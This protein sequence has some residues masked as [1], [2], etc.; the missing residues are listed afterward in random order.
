MEC[1]TEVRWQERVIAELYLSKVFEYELLRIK[2]NEPYF[3]FK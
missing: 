2:I 1:Y 3:S